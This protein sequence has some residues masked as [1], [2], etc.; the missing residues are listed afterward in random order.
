MLSLGNLDRNLRRRRSGYSFL[1]VLFAVFLLGCSATIVT[2]AMPAA[3]R[4]RSKADQGNRAAALAQREMES[5]RGLGYANLNATQ[6]FGNGLVDSA[7]A[8]GDGGLS[9]TSVDSGSGDAAS[10]A[11][12]SGQG[13]IW[14]TQEDIE[15]RRVVVQM[16][17]TERGKPRS[18]SLSTLVANL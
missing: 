7:V 4:S 11:L 13:E 17:W 18:Y 2:A 16:R 6:L 15:L 12:P 8:D 5:V 14:I 10:A 1:E 3:S 9:W